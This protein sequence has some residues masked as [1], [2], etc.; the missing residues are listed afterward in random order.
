M[1]KTAPAPLQEKDMNSIV[2]VENLAGL[3]SQLVRNRKA[4][5]RIREVYVG[6]IKQAVN[7]VETNLLLSLMVQTR[8]M[9][10]GKGEYRLFYV[11]LECWDDPSLHCWSDG[12]A[13]RFR[14]IIERWFAYNTTEQRYGSWRDVK[15]VFQYYKDRRCWASDKQTVAWRLS[16]VLTMIADV[17]KQQIKEDNL[18]NR[19][20]LLAKWLPREK[21]AFAWQV[22]IFA[23]TMYGY[24]RP[25]A[26]LSKVSK[27]HY[28]ARYRRMLSY[29]SQAT[30]AVQR[31]QCENEWSHI[32]FAKD[33]TSLTMSRQ[34]HAFMLQ[35]SSV[36]DQM[37]PK[38]LQDRQECKKNYLSYLERQVR[39]KQRSGQSIGD[40]VREAWLVPEGET[41]DT[42]MLQLAYDTKVAEVEV[43]G[44]LRNMC[45]MCD[46]SDSMRT[47]DCHLYDAIG[48][49]MLIAETSV[50][51]PVMLIFAAQP[52]LI[53]LKPTDS[54]IQKIATIRAV[55]HYAGARTDICKAYGLL[56]ARGQKK[57]LSTQDAEKLQ[58]V[59]LSDMEISAA[60]SHFAG[61]GRKKLVASLGYAQTPPVAYWNMQLT[62]D[63][64]V[65]TN[66][67]GVTLISGSASAVFTALCTD[68]LQHWSSARGVTQLLSSERY[69]FF[70]G[71]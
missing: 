59:I 19:P 52:R 35:G 27:A 21:S 70:A 57:G 71:S 1:N 25:W 12:I 24:K 43:S 14:H 23:Y 22:P 39:G 36:A 41:R 9:Y 4:E 63:F 40:L 10:Y 20:S 49:S 17:V 15:G 33:V 46:T 28:L 5:S 3:Y 54:F 48:I 2:F 47:G 29:L 53:H 58:L 56:L 62:Q 61:A 68:S 32:D 37:S 55:A 50:V 31:L 8:D 26:T 69:S 45:P 44:T 65:A 7:E 38:K 16:P 60:D 42:D 51:G 18:A 64:P 66:D 11:L 34:H 6:L 13:S 67:D 30:C